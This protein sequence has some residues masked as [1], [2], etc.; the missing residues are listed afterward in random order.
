MKDVVLTVGAPTKSRSLQMVFSELM[1]VISAARSHDGDFL[2]SKIHIA[3][4]Q[5]L[6]SPAMTPDNLPLTQILGQIWL[7][8]SDHK[9]LNQGHLFGTPHM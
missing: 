3:S 6:S 1:E 5:S 8:K 7:R 9:M 2:R 4:K